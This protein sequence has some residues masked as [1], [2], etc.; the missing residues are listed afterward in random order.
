MRAILPTVSNPLVRRL[1]AGVALSSL[2][3]GLTMPFLYVYLAQVRGIPGPTVGLIFACMGLASFVMAPVAG[4]LIDRFGPRLIVVIGLLIEAVA[5]AGI[6]WART[7]EG[8]LLVVTVLSVGMA[9]LYPATFALLTRLVREHERERVYA[10]NFMLINAGIGMGG[11]IASLIVDTESVAS[12]QRLYVLDALTYVVYAGIVASL[13]PGTGRLADESIPG[14]APGGRSADGAKAGWRV[15]L[16]DRALLRFMAVSVLVVTFGYAQMEAGLTAFATQVGELPVNRLGWA[17]AANTLF[18]VLGQL[19]ALRFITGRS[20]ARLLALAAVIWSIGWLVI[21]SSGR[22]DGLLATVCV[23]AGMAVF[24][25]GETLWAPVAPALVNDLA[26][27]DLRGR[28]NAAQS[29][30]WTVSGVIGPATAG[31][32]IGNDLAGVWSILVVGGTA[33]AAV[34]F[35]GLRSHLTPEQDGRTPLVSSVCAPG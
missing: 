17:F 11:L 10:V 7:P 21:I 30:V 18:I 1:F 9:S 4:S 14:A 19:V 31:M 2:G 5:T 6:G 22:I 16:A 34:L 24:G 33:L 8:A 13:P 20:R 15:V 28:Y 27:E 25:I 32:L 35:L 26:R 23:V 29:L 12:F 3:N